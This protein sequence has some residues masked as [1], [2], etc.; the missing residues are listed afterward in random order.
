MQ[1]KP[2]KEKQGTDERTGGKNMKLMVVEAG[3]GIWIN[4]YIHMCM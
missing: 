2:M 4:I 3:M 1:R